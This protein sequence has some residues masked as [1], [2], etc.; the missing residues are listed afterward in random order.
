MTTMQK[1]RRAMF[2]SLAES[3][4]EFGCEVPKLADKFG[5]FLLLGGHKI[6]LGIAGENL[7]MVEAVKPSGN[8]TAF[9]LAKFLGATRVVLFCHNAIGNRQVIVGIGRK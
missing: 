8:V 7:P 9:R 3:A 2:R 4:R 5:G 6:W 1:I